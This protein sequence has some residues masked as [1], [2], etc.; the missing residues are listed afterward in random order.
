L[1]F[2]AQ[3]RP[4]IVRGTP[5]VW[6]RGEGGLLD[7]QVHPDHMRNGWIYLAYSDP[8][9]ADNTMTAIVRG[10]IGKD[11]AWIDE[12]TIFKADASTY[13]GANSHFG[14][15]IAFQ[16]GYVYFSIGD[17]VQTELA[18]DLTS[19][20]GKIHRLHDD[21][22]VPKDNP[23]VRVNAALASIW[24]IGHR[25]PQGLTVHPHTGTLWSS[26]HGPMGGDEINIVR[27]GRNYGWPLV[28]FG[29][30]YDGTIVSESPYREGVEPPLHQWTPSIGVS[31]IEFYVGDRLPAWRNSLIVASLGGQALHL[32]RI[33]G[34]KVVNDEVLFQGLGRIRDVVTGP[35]G[36][37]YVAINDPNGTIY[38][39]VNA[40][41]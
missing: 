29:R 8:D 25:N 40:A 2:D 19:P 17:R 33:D 21:G 9:A 7:V 36:H 14:S 34:E 15:R 1:V 32:L 37:L 4:S 28:S 13:D 39:I 27:P 22:R 18:Q 23:Y 24:S 5:Q 16:D 10:R 12:Q 6:N 20:F 11:L 38:R 3:M 30:H 41:T 26:E 35:D 31:Q